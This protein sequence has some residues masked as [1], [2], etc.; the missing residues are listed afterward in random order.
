[1]RVTSHV[2]RKDQGRS[3]LRA[4][5]VA[6]IRSASPNLEMA[7]FCRDSYETRARTHPPDE[8]VEGRMGVPSCM[9]RLEYKLE[10]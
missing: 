6:S 3:G 5:L 9:V 2:P 7:Y 10:R 8:W 1:M 4:R